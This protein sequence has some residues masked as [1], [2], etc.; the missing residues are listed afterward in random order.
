MEVTYKIKPRF[1]KRW[2]IGDVK[3][4]DLFETKVYSEWYDPSYGNGG[5]NFIIQEDTIKVRTFATYAEAFNYK[6]E[7]E[8]L[9]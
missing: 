6:L 1:K 7:L 8:E 3:V 4:Y 9:C 5:G 2:F